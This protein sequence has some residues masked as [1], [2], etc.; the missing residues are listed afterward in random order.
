MAARRAAHR[1][2]H[3]RRAHRRPPQSPISST[4]AQVAIFDLLEDNSFAPVSALDGPVPSPSGVDENRL[5]LDIRD[6]EG[7]PLERVVLPLSP[8]RSSSR[9]IS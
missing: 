4:S 8:F 3:A 6:T 2:D 1:P 7:Q 9:T 5:L